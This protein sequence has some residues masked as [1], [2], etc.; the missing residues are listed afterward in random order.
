MVSKP[1][2]D[3]SAGSKI[4]PLPPN[5]AELFKYNSIPISP[6]T[7]VPDISYSLYEVN[8][9]KIKL[10][11][12]LSYHASGI[13]VSQRATWV[14]LGWSLMPG[15][16][17]SRE[18]RGVADETTNGG[19]FNHYSSVD[20]LDKIQNYF[21]M[22]NWYQNHPDRQPDFFTYNIP[23]KSGKYLYSREASKFVNFPYQ[24][25]IIKRINGNDYEITDDDGTKYVFGITQSVTPDVIPIK[26]SIQSWFLTQIISSDMRD[27]FFLRYN[28]TSVSGFD[29]NAGSTT[30]STFT[31]YSNENVLDGKYTPGDAVVTTSSDIHYS[32]LTLSEIVFRQ[33]KVT[34]YS[35]GE[36]SDKGTSLDSVVV[37]AKNA[38]NYNRV[39]KISFNYGY[40]FSG[41]T[42]PEPTDYRL[43]L[44][45][46]TKENLSGGQ[47][48]TYK[49]EYDNVQ[50]PNIN[51]YAV[52]FFGFYNGATSNG[53]LMPNILPKQDQ[54]KGWG[55][56][57]QAN[58]DPSQLHM[59]AGMLRKIIHPTGGYTTFD[60]E[61][62]KYESSSV[63]D[64]KVFVARLEV[65]GTGLKYKVWDSTT[66]QVQ[67][68]TNLSR[69]PVDITVTFSPF[70][71]STF[72]TAEMVILRDVT[73]G[74][75]IQM[76]S[77][78]GLPDYQNT[79]NS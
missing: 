55:P 39:R 1:E 54:L 40:F 12:T 14:G 72:E 50:P 33:G 21:V 76:W 32:L 44:Q 60:Y 57:G 3:V 61:P 42:S 64:T 11:I 25:V 48:E 59:M 10:P 49:F 43:K 31:Y 75:D 24:P 28:D 9:G 29:N 68:T 73:E 20:T 6:M 79:L 4:I 34:F 15:A 35:K 74:R 51:S 17:I 8:T 62:N 7:G 52:D 77:T 69:Q 22:D 5:A 47:P 41:S 30:T 45:S 53:D 13:K 26:S 23:G 71:F 58:R 38:D 56:I 18:I 63:T 27:T 19:W 78:D 16:N 36:R 37:Y 67:S 2:D 65:T 70:S 46:F 66:F